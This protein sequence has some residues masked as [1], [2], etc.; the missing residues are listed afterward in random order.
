VCTRFLLLVK[1][2][3]VHSCAWKLGKGPTGDGLALES[4]NAGTN[5]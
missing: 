2:V 5:G 3:K 4:L 1:G